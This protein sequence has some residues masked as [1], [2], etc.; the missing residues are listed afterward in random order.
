MSLALRQKAKWPGYGSS[1]LPN[2]NAA[3]SINARGRK[4]ELGQSGCAFIART[5][6]SCPIDRIV[7]RGLVVET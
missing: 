1:P 6:K 5:A 7:D 4:R 2:G 3:K